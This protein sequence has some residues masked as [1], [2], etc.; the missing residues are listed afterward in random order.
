[1]TVS[2]LASVC[3]LSRT[4]VLY[5]ESQGLLKPAIRCDSNYCV[6]GERKLRL[7]ARFACIAVS[8]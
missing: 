5:Y 3:G 8:A 7:C 4:T 1:M 2:R 6:Y